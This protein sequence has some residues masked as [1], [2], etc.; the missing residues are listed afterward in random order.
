MPENFAHLTDA[1]HQTTCGKHNATCTTLP[2]SSSRMHHVRARGGSSLSC[3]ELLLSE[4]VICQPTIP[5]LSTELLLRGC[6]HSSRNFA[7]KY[8]DLWNCNLDTNQC[9]H[10]SPQ[11]QF[12]HAHQFLRR[13]LA[14]VTDD[15][16][17]NKMREARRRVY[18][19]AAQQQQQQAGPCACAVSSLYCGELHLS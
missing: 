10:F 2:H 7:R 9:L 6:A 14:Y 5:H 3:G 16:T 12:F 19:R 4:P 1:R 8:R 13:F 17:P 18:G 11:R 15:K